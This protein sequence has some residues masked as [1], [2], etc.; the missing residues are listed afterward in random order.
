MGEAFPRALHRGS[1]PK[2]EPPPEDTKQ[3]R[4]QVCPPGKY[5]YAPTRES[6]QTLVFFFLVFG[7][8]SCSWFCS[9]DNKWKLSST[10]SKAPS[11]LPAHGHC[12]AHPR[13]KCL[14]HS[15]GHNL[16]S[17]PRNCPLS[18]PQNQPYLLHL[19]FYLTIQRVQACDECLENSE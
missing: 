11:F 13:S 19:S 12:P 17:H 7:C 15:V 18:T 6:S 9:A 16:K 8:P 5:K 4:F 2:T 10:E 1:N 14:L 3:E